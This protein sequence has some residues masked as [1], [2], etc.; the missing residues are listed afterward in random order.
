MHQWYGMDFFFYFAPTCK[1]EQVDMYHCILD[2][3]LALK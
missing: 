1:K 3:Y 2:V